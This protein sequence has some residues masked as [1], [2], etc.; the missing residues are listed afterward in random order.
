MT[1][2][3]NKYSPIETKDK[4]TRFDQSSNINFKEYKHEQSVVLRQSP[5]WSRAIMLTL[6]GL[7]CFGIGWAFLAKIEQVVPATGELKPQ[8]FVKDI[9]APATGVVKTVYVKD[10]QKVK[11]GDL[12][13]TFDSQA[14]RDELDYLLKVRN[15][16]VQEDEIYRKLI[17]T[18]SP[19]AVQAEIL[20]GSLPKEAASLLKN[21][22]EL[23]A[24][25]ELLRS[26]LG[27]SN[28]PSNLGVDE[29]QRLLVAKKEL[30]SRAQAGQLGVEETKKQ[31][32][33]VQAKLN[34]TKQSL[35]IEQKVL[36]QMQMLFKEGA[37]TQL[38]YLQQ[39]EHVQE[40]Q[41]QIAQEEQE[42]QRL[43][44]DVAKGN[45]DLNNSLAVDN[46]GVLDKIADNKQQIANID[47]QLSK[48]LLD[49]EK[50]LAQTN[51]KIAQTQINVKYQQL[52]APVAGTIFDLQAKNPGFVA[53]TG[54][55]VLT[56]VPDNDLVAQIFITNKDIGFVHP[57]MKA[58]VRIDSF[59]FSEYGDIKGQLTWVGSDALPPD[60]TH[61][62]Y[63]F[64][65][66]IRLDRQTLKLQDKNITLQ[67]GMSISANIKVRENRTVMSLFTEMFNKQ[68]DNFKQV[69]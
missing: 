67:S 33:E 50:Q 54:E 52:R 31:L 40:L 69:R 49:N 15:S 43:Q 34:N 6:I 10:G 2:L 63:R 48:I 35:V 64:P 28:T 51:S 7:A 45:Q 53:Q 21:R 25:N 9:Q 13:L 61:Q 57:G 20:S 42:Q 60:Q 37:G 44:L 14:N 58:D 26:E 24:Q 5:I 59:P 36:D 12:L 66:K 55:K 16:L 1:Q 32:A 19:Q 38:Q 46:K 29:Q 17:N 39:K 23:V 41:S 30:A 65:A 8:G 27:S 18:G 62:F 3:N 56:I 11:A 68:A 47:S 4:N 22:A